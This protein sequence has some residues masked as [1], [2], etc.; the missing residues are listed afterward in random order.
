MRAGFILFV[1]EHSTLH[2]KFRDEDDDGIFSY[3]K[4]EAFLIYDSPILEE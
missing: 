2:S 3:K 1:K 4:N